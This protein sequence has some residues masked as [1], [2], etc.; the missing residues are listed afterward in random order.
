[1][2]WTALALGCRMPLGGDCFRGLS[3]NS[4]RCHCHC[5]CCR[6]TSRLLHR[7]DGDLGLGTLVGGGA[8]LAPFD[9]SRLD[10]GEGDREAEAWMNL[11]RKWSPQPCDSGLPDIVVVMSWLYV[12]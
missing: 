5:R 1:M 2:R 3:W 6:Y 10:R 11:S 8:G 9:T 4:C 12:G 7:R